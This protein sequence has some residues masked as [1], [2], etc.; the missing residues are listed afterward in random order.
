MKRLLL[1]SVAF[2]FGV[3]FSQTWTDGKGLVAKYRDFK[4]DRRPNLE[5]DF[6]LA[7]NVSV[8]SKPQGLD[9]ASNTMNIHSVPDPKNPKSYLVQHA[10]A[11]GQVTVVKTIRSKTGSEITRIVGAKAD[12]TSGPSEAVVKMDGPMEIESYDELRRPTM[13]ATGKS[14]FATLE[15][16]TQS[17][18]DNGLR[19]A[20]MDG[21]VKLVLKQIDGKTKKFLTIR[22]ASDHMMLENQGSGKRIT[23]TGSVHIE[24]D[25]VGE[26]SKAKSAII[27]ISKNGDFHLDTSGVK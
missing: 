27:V 10:V 22:T 4:M 1:I 11:V 25:N 7:G 21:N 15:P 17:N 2:L 13:T 18:L 19:K 20:E 5:Y 26:L 6:S 24:G 23:L 14:G 8:A 9:L 3:S 16:L 12:Y